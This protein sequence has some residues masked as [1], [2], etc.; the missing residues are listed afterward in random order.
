MVVGE[1]DRAL[2]TWISGDHV[3]T[4]SASMPLTQLIDVARTV[5]QV[6]AREWDGMRFQAEHNQASTTRYEHSAAHTL[7]TGPDS[8]SPDSSSHVA[9]ATAVVGGQRQISWSWGGNGLATAPT[10]RAQIHTMVA[11]NSTYVLADLPRNVSPS[12]FLNVVQNG[13]QFVMPF[14]DFDPTVDRTFAAFTVALPGPF[15]VEILGADGMI[16]AVW[17]RQ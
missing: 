13:H 3:I 5:H 12:G 4:V 16:K 6:S 15:T 8:S 11:T 14:I 2:A 10:D 1:D 17:P 7:A 9:V